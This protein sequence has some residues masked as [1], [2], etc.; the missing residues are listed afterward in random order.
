MFGFFLVQYKVLN[1]TFNMHQ[2][3]WT[4]A[5]LTSMSRLYKEEE[6]LKCFWPGEFRCITW[7]PKISNMSARTRRSTKNNTTKWC[8]KYK[9]KHDDNMKRA[10]HAHTH[11][12]TLRSKYIQFNTFSHMCWHIHLCVRSTNFMWNHEG[13]VCRVKDCRTSVQLP[14]TQWLYTHKA[15]QWSSGHEGI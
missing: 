15:F 10:L 3:L 1:L 8:F 4:P 11:T 2:P 14:I 7:N 5:Y 6:V 13:L 12:H 9:L